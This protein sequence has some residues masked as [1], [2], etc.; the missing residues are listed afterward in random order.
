MKENIIKKSE[1]P[2]GFIGAGTMGRGIAQAFI[3]NNFKVV[4][5]EKNPQKSESAKNYILKGL[6]K[7]I[8]LGKITGSQKDDFIVN[9]LFTENINDLKD[10]FLVIEAVNEDIRLKRDIFRKVS[11]VT[12]PETIL[13]TNTSTLSI[14]KISDGF[15]NVEHILGIHFLILPKK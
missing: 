13:A 1:R 15:K 7:L 12:K 9:F 14:D 4:I 8:E 3:Q 5:L 10:S 2:V 11:E 6:F